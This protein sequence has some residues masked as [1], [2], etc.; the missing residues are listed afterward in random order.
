MESVWILQSHT[1]PW[2][3]VLPCTLQVC[4]HNTNMYPDSA[5]AFSAVISLCNLLESPAS[6]FEVLCL[7]EFSVFLPHLVMKVILI[8]LIFGV[9]QGSMLGLLFGKLLLPLGTVVDPMSLIQ[10][11]LVHCKVSQG[12]R[13][14]SLFQSRGCDQTG[15]SGITVWH[16]VVAEP[17]NWFCLCRIIG[18]SE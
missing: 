14:F 16:L 9:P 15:L 4:Y 3:S 17:R 12:V 13:G 7:I 1:S 11:I 18:V 5:S 2:I 8:T 6:C 10:C